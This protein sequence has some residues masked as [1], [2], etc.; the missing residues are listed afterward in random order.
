M[1]LEVE[2]E[3]EVIKN[4]IDGRALHLADSLENPPG[5]YCPDLLREDKRSL[6]QSPCTRRQPHM[7]L[8]APLA[9]RDGEDND[10]ARRR[11]VKLIP[12]HD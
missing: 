1:R 11:I 3:A 5:A 12:R 10:E 6:A 2:D 7:R 9:G 4:L 8:V